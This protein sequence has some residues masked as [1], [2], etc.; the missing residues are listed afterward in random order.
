MVS[1]VNI[2]FPREG[3][4]P[5][6]AET[7]REF[8]PIA[9]WK[10]LLS[11]YT[12]NWT[13]L[14]S[15]TQ[16]AL[17]C[18]DFLDQCLKN[19]RRYKIHWAIIRTPQIN[20]SNIPKSECNSSLYE[21]LYSKHAKL[22]AVGNDGKRYISRSNKTLFIENFSKNQ[23]IKIT[24]PESLKQQ[25]DNL[26]IVSCHPIENGLIIVTQKAVCEWRYNNEELRFYRSY[27]LDKKEFKILSS[28]Y[29]DGILFLECHAENEWYTR[30]CLDLSVQ[31]PTFCDLEE[32]NFYNI[33]LSA[34]GHL[35]KVYKGNELEL[36]KLDISSSSFIPQG[37]PLPLKGKGDDVFISI[38]KWFIKPLESKNA[39]HAGETN[40]VVI[41]AEKNK[42]WMENEIKI[43][44]RCHLG[45]ENLHI[46]DDFLFIQLRAYLQVFHLPSKRDY[47]EKFRRLLCEILQY[48][49]I[50][51]IAFIEKRE[52]GKTYL[53]VLFKLTTYEEMSEN[54][55]FIVELPLTLD[56]KNESPPVPEIP[57]VKQP[58]PTHIKVILVVGVVLLLI[59]AGACIALKQLRLEIGPNFALTK[60][61]GV[62]G[63]GTSLT[64][65][66]IGSYKWWK[67]SKASQSS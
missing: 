56:G 59:T 26:D 55:E 24:P 2:L 66:A 1:S 34:D 54:K 17:V 3:E 41:D 53:K 37:E 29:K 30:K 16:V 62:V 5:K 15:V 47:S 9:S 13:C 40:I 61:I 50:L 35:F 8:N 12:N 14:R 52:T 33:L 19:C 38:G 43:H 67:R 20:F 42:I 64:I 63:G 18:R 58:L 57:I 23:L 49:N 28:G 31:N 11:A 45:A 10:I 46:V 60:V 39:W 44:Y 7:L 22:L 36:Q 51:S 4:P 21:E 27:I 65:L 48:N 6:K 25:F 32:S